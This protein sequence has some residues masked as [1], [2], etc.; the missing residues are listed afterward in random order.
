MP[1]RCYIQVN[2]NRV[3]LILTPLNVAAK[4][5]FSNRSI[6]I[7]SHDTPHQYDARI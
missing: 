3:P 4:H 7:A 1:L 2:T 5:Y 6:H